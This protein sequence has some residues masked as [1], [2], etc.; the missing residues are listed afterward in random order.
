M[1]LNIDIKDEGKKSIVQLSGEID[2]YTAPALRDKLI[3]L[4]EK[5]GHKIKIDLE[6][7]SY[8][9]ST[10]LGVFINAY[11]S[12]KQHNSIIEII[13]VKDRVLRLFQV[14]GLHEIMNVVP[15]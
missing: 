8:L 9:D 14:T 5:A 11:K 12:S 7:I 15:K 2:V 1:N 10:G 13:H 3:P 4:T 6:N